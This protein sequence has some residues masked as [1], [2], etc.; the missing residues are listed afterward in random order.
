MTSDYAFDVSEIDF[1]R[2]L[3][4][5]VQGVSPVKQIKRAAGTECRGYKGLQLRAENKE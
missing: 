4:Q 2:S 3:S 1:S 5:A